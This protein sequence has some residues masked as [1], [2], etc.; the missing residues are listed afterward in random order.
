VEDRVTVIPGVLVVAGSFIYE[1][2]TSTCLFKNHHF[3]LLPVWKVEAFHVVCSIIKQFIASN[4][5]YQKDVNKYCATDVIIFN[6]W[7]LFLVQFGC[8]TK[9]LYVWPRGRKQEI[10]R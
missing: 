9:N 1:C 8:H 7:Y 6:I 5:K 2:S 3:Q 4:M 10:L